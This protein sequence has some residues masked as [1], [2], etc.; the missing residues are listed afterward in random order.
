MFKISNKATQRLNT[1]QLFIRMLWEERLMV[2]LAK[3][4]MSITHHVFYMPCVY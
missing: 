3:K 4:N 2:E 1:K